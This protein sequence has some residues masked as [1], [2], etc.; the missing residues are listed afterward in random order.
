MPLLKT[1]LDSMAKNMKNHTQHI[2]TTLFYVA[3][4]IL[5]SEILLS[6]GDNSPC[7]LTIIMYKP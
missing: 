6:L 4:I 3:A 7:N 1:K 2:F 5:E